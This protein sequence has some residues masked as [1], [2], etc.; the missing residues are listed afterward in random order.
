MRPPASKNS[1]KER[2]TIE[3]I[4]RAALLAGLVFLPVLGLGC[5]E[6][7]GQEKKALQAEDLVRRG[8]SDFSRKDYIKARQDFEQALALDQSNQKAANALA[9]LD[10]L[11]QEKGLVAKNDAG[12]LAGDSAAVKSGD[13]VSAA[14]MVDGSLVTATEPRE[15]WLA[16]LKG[17]EA[18]QSGDYAALLDASD[19]ALAALSPDSPY[20]Y[21]VAKSRLAALILNH[22]YDDA[23]DAVSDLI[24]AAPDDPGLYSMAT[25]SYQR[26][27][28]IGEAVS[29]AETAYGMDSSNP[30]HQNN[31]AY[32]YA[33][34]GENLDL[35]YQLAAS[36]VQQQPQSPACLDTMAWVLYQG[37]DISGAYQ[38][39][40]QA[41]SQLPGPIQ[42][43][44]MQQH[45]QAIINEFLSGGM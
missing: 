2:G 13:S 18:Y 37:G 3:R 12:A 24:S 32:T 17:A 38:Y 16:Y 31:L 41:V 33:V 26:A 45:Y 20:Y 34:A 43:Q 1:S 11:V 9:W 40:Q 5:G 22:D 29:A 25:L 44:E 30:E 7:T 27:G 15:F 8:K 23:S 28:R 21:D 10:R 42:D 6:M 36:A 39:I 35:A 19:E 14:S 4:F